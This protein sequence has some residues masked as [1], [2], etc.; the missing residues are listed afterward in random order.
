MPE[1]ITIQNGATL[2]TWRERIVTVTF[3]PTLEIRAGDL[4]EW[5]EGLCVDFPF[6]GHPKTHEGTSQENP[7]QVVFAIHGE[8]ARAVPLTDRQHFQRRV[9]AKYNTRGTVTALVE[10]DNSRCHRGTTEA[11]VSGIASGRFR[12]S[13][14]APLGSRRY[15]LAMGLCTPS[16]NSEEIMRL[17]R[18]VADMFGVFVRAHT[19]TVV[20]ANPNDQ[21]Q[22]AFDWQGEPFPEFDLAG[23]KVPTD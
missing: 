6:L 16:Y 17:L 5:G 9:G 13:S 7:F 3:N 22:P 19:L 8:D 21:L 11:G 23:L 4:E 15:E 2:L 14:S 12:P 20:D 1:A 18:A 10:R